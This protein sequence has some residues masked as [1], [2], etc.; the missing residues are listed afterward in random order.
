MIGWSMNVLAV[1]IGGSLG[2]LGRYGLTLL[3]THSPLNSLIAGP[4]RWMG[5]GAGFATTIANLLGCAAL[6]AL[7]QWV[8]GTAATGSTPLSP[9]TLLA[10]RVGFLGSLTTFS[11]LIGDAT[12]LSMENR[13]VASLTLLGVNLFAG[14]ALFWLAAAFVRGA[15]S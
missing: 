2:A 3:F 15:A 8:E 12:V 10:L 13:P 11:T 5:G 6:G 1:A 4:A 14:L 9:R 7:Y